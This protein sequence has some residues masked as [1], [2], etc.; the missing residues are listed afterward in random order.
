[1]YSVYNHP[2]T[3][4]RVHIPWKYGQIISF[5][6]FQKYL[7]DHSKIFAKFSSR[8]HDPD[9]FSTLSGE[10]LLEETENLS[11]VEES[12]ETEEKSYSRKKTHEV[13]EPA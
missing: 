8:I 1:M 13:K 7:L 2:I 4:L 6:L 9:L 10:L 11:L 3:C 12:Q 5:A